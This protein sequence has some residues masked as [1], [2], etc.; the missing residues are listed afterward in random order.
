MNTFAEKRELID[1]AVKRKQLHFPG[2]ASHNKTAV[3]K[4]KKLYESKSE[5]KTLKEI[6]ILVGLSVKTIQRYAKLDEW[7]R[8]KDCR[9][10]DPKKKAQAKRL[11]ESQKGYQMV[12]ISDRTG[13]TEATL[14]KWAKKEGWVR[15]GE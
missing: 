7:E 6:S 2:R 14:Y 9:T 11:Y 8:G 10:A 12:D 3:Q 1:M 4:A 5:D 15:G 13:I